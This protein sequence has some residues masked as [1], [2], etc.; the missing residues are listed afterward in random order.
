[1]KIATLLIAATA[2]VPAAAS[3]TGTSPLAGWT[4][5]STNYVQ[6]FDALA[7]T[8]TSNVLPAGFQIVE[9]GDGSAADGRYAAGNGSSNGGNAYS[10]GAN[11][12]TDRA[13]GSLASGSVGPV[14]LGG[15]FTNGLGATIS[16]L[17]FAFTG[18]QWRAGNSSNDGLFFEYS[19][20][21]TALDNGSWT[22]LGALDF[23]PL[24]LSGN[25]ALDGDANSTAISA[26]LSGL[27]IEAGQS[28]AFRW[29]DYNSSA[30]DHGLAIDDL[31]IATTLAQS[32]AVPE[33]ATWAM[34]TLGFGLM[35]GAL[36]AG[37]RS[38]RLTF[39]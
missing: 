15:L 26:A 36:R 10:F 14:Y 27:S 28:F 12:S 23:L 19:L 13:L 1:M 18:E 24:V 30:N 38:G 29:V 25:A 31:S 9:I 33:P 37:K 8:G 35:G 22:A 34:L 20:D 17:A 6:D 5:D 21:A 11:G 3:A 7:A 32:P 2:L 4:L 16:D 39:A